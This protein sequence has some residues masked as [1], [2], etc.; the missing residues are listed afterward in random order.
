M[1]LFSQRISDFFVLDQLFQFVALPF[2][3]SSS[4]CVF[5]KSVAPVL[6]LL[7]SQGIPIVGYSDNLLL[8]EQLAETLSNSGG[9]RPS[10]S[11]IV[12]YMLRNLHWN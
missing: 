9:F 4:P 11:F 12:C 6:A 2:S 8:R 10:K 7:C 1:I 3:L 5:I